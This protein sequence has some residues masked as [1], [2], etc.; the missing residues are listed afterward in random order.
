M[1][2]SSLFVVLVLILLGCAVYLFDTVTHAQGDYRP[3]V[4]GHTTI[5]Y[6]EETNIVS[7]YAET[8]IDYF[9]DGDYEA[10]VNLIVKDDNGNIIASRSAFDNFDFGSISVEIEFPARPD[11]TYTATG[12][13]HANA[14]VYEDDT[15]LPRGSPNYGI[16]YDDPW[17]FSNFEGQNIYAP[18]SYNFISPG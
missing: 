16:W 8:D 10:Q 12:S 15:D 13:Y 9:V 18:W 11:T 17:G 7:A 3:Y 4:F 1:K 2:N 5:D 6:D 14:T